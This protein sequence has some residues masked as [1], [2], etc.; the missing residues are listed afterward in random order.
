LDQLIAVARL[1]ADELQQHEAKIALIEETAGPSAVAASPVVAAAPV[2]AAVLEGLAG[3]APAAANVG[4]RGSGSRGP[5]YSPIVFRYICHDIRSIYRKSRGANSAS[6]IAG[7]ASQAPTDAETGS[8]RTGTVKPIALKTRDDFSMHGVVL[9]SDGGGYGFLQFLE[10]GGPV[11]PKVAGN[12]PVLERGHQSADRRSW[13]DPKTH[14]VPPL[15]R[16]A[17]RR[18]LDTRAQQRNPGGHRV[19]PRAASGFGPG[20]QRAVAGAAR[21][22]PVDQPVASRRVH[23]RRRQRTSD[24]AAEPVAFAVRKPQAPRHVGGRG[25]T[26]LAHG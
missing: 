21:P 18:P 19:R 3:M 10:A 25:F 11:R 15:E 22:E 16:E 20:D 12:P 4:V 23:R 2:M 9:H 13:Q 7:C 8:K 5:L 1:V 6:K 24:E 26:A 14:P 17:R